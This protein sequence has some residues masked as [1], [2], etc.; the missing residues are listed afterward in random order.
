MSMAFADVSVAET[1][2]YSETYKT[3]LLGERHLSCN[4]Q[5]RTVQ[6]I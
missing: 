4:K 3:Q 6:V 2:G 5:V 1:A